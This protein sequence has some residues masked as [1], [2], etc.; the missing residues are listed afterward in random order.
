M[1]WL[2]NNN[3]DYEAAKEIVIHDRFLYFE[4]DICYRNYNLHVIDSIDNL[5]SPRHLKSREQ[6]GLFGGIFG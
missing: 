3:L 5:P 6:T 4:L 2:L 1:I